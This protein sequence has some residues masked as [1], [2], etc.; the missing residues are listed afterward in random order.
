MDDNGNVLPPGQIGIIAVLTP[1]PVA[2]L[3][4]WN[5]PKATAVCI[6]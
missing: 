6:D 4:Y 3:Y 1:D 5:N 2:F